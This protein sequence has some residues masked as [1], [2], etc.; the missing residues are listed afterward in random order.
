MKEK[1]KYT[2]LAT[3]TTFLY[4]SDVAI[5]TGCIAASVACDCPIFL[6]VSVLFFMDALYS[7]SRMLKRCLT[8][9]FEV[10][11]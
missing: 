1:I 4:A 8:R 5:W 7:M 9:T 2:H 11:E 3:V 6:V 10:V